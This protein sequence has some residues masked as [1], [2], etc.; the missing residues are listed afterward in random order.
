LLINVNHMIINVYVTHNNKC[1]CE[2][3]VTECVI[4]FIINKKV[5]NKFNY[6]CANKVIKVLLDKIQNN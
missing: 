4:Y 1:I 2:N 6:I 3:C 5:D